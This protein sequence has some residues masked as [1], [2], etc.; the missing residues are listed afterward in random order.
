MLGTVRPNCAQVQQLECQGDRPSGPTRAPLAATSPPRPEQRDELAAF[1]SLDH[2]VGAQQDARG[3]RKAECPCCLQID[4]QLELGRLL[5][6]KVSC[7]SAFAELGPHKC[8]ID[9]RLRGC[10][11]HSSLGHPL[12]PVRATDTL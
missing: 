8:P 9:D 2:L 4:H 10:L 5:H 3:H 7:L 1:Q 11:C 6:R 12:P